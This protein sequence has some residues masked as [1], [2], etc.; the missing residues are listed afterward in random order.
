M[1][2]ALAL[3]LG[4]LLSALAVESISR[5]YVSQHGWPLGDRY[6]V[7]PT[8]YF[9][10]TVSPAPPHYKDLRFR[11]TPDSLALLDP[12]G[13]SFEY[14]WI[15]P[16]GTYRVVCVGDSITQ[17][18]PGQENYTHSL[19]RALEAK[20]STAVE[21]IPLGVGGYNPRLSLA[22]FSGWV[23]RLDPDI[24]VVQ[25]G[26]NDVDNLKLHHHRPHGGMPL[27]N[28]RD[29]RYRT[30]A[31][32]GLR[33]W[34]T[35]QPA[36]NPRSHA[37]WWFS[38]GLND[39]LLGDRNFGL[40]LS[41]DPTSLVRAV[42]G[43]AQLAEARSID[44]VGVIFPFFEDRHTDIEG[45]RIS[46]ILAEAGLPVLELRTPLQTL[47]S[48]SALSVDGIH[49]DQKAHRLAGETIARYLFPSES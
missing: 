22:A 44:S 37:A 27:P 33:G 32:A 2:Q 20:L 47:G 15:K 24:L 3:L 4:L 16:K 13:Q 7:V 31:S 21:V 10:Q 11:A 25:L 9:T 17:I 12:E 45:A 19:Q 36:L 30:R 35:K 46:G 14:S 34:N 18:W 49:P 39:L 40:R 41:H 42:E 28:L 48:L 26:P 8:P 29:A 6:D 5:L 1:K 38:F 43:Y 23:H